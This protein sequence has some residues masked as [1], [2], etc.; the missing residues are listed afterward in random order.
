MGMTA[1]SIASM[2]SILD[3]RGHDHSLKAIVGFCCL[4][5]AASLCL[6]ALGTDLSAGWL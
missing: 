5:L 2:G 1:I 3:T 6:A 4:G